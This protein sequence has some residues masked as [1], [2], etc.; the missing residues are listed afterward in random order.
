[1]FTPV[2]KMNTVRILLPLAA[3]LDWSL[4]Q[5]D[6]KNVLLHGDLEK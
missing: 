4:Y 1:M 6:V 3:M 2:E 5:F